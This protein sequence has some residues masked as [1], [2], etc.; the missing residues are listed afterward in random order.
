[1]RQH[2]TFHF[3]QIAAGCACLMFLLW[4]TNASGQ[5]SPHGAISIPCTN[6]HTTA[7]WNA[8]SPTM[9]FDHASTAFPLL[10]E[11]RV[12]PCRKCHTTLRFTGTVRTCVGCHLEAYS[13]AQAVNHRTAGFSTECAD[14]HKEDAPSWQASF[15][16][17]RTRF[18]TRGIHES[19]PCSSCHAEGRYRGTPSECLSC[20]LSQYMGTT[21][22]NHAAAGFPTTCGTCH[23]ALTWIPATL[24][25]HPYFPIGRSDRHSPGVWNTCIDC[26]VAQP[27]YNVFECINCHAH[28]KTRMDSRHREIRSYTYASTACYG[29]H[30][31]P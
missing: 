13:N 2:M 9:V 17:D 16:H 3:H 21:A 5:T 31:N 27:S 30:R 20:H 24:F 7:G 28:E 11:H 19:V 10:G 25:A 26:H 8:L 4:T 23:R 18:P 22:P 12:T 14:C 1:M 15:D 29:C 6:C